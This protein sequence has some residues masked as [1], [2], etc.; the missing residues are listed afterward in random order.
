MRRGFTTTEVGVQVSQHLSGYICT[1]RV[2]KRNN[3]DAEHDSP[4]SSDGSAYVTWERFSSVDKS[5]P[6]FGNMS[7][8]RINGSL[9]RGHF[10]NPD[11]RGEVRAEEPRR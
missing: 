11:G 7:C 8:H 1:D 10:E 9:G 5:E 2:T 4:K 3:I 6:V